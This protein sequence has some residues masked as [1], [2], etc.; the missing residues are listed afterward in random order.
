MCWFDPRSHLV[1]LLIKK[2]F[3]VR[4]IDN[5]QGGHLK[6]LKHHKNRNLIK[7]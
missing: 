3:E 1:D 6:N 2:N 4:V 7:N 5:L